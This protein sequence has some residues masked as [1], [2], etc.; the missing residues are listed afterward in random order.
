MLAP[1]E[2][3]LQECKNVRD[4]LRDTLRFAYSSKSSK[5][6]YA[7]CFQRLQLIE[8]AFKTLD[9]DNE[10]ILEELSNQLSDLSELIGRVERSRIEEFS[11]PFALALQSLALK[12]CTA[13][14]REGD[15][16]PCFF[17]SADDELN[18]YQ[19]ITEQSVPGFI[20][21]PLFNIIFP[22][23]L[24]N[25]VLLHPILGHELG[26]AAISAPQHSQMLLE[27]VLNPLTAK[28]PLQDL[29]KFQKWLVKIKADLDLDEQ[30]RAVD[31]WQEELYC[32][33]FGL[34]LMGPSYVG[35]T[36]SLLRP[37]KTRTASDSHPPSLTRFWVIEQAV[38]FLGWRA[39]LLKR[40]PLNKAIKRYFSSL[41]EL[42]SGVP[43]KY[44]LLSARQIQESLERLD[45]FLDTIP[46]VKCPT[47]D[48]NQIARMRA[49]MLKGCPPVA[50]DI[51][52]NLKIGNPSVDFRSVL[53]AGWLTWMSEEH[54]KSALDFYQLNMLCQR[55]ILQQSAVDVWN[56]YQ[57]KDTS[58][59]P[60][61]TGSTKTNS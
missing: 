29:T 22:R 6:V 10:D 47:Q 56:S 16:A 32:D 23:S 27:D 44:R 38:S 17:I 30:T 61:L 15:S 21:T 39:S 26:H 1:S 36:T 59:R 55:G 50:T 35:A 25:F 4:L 60:K 54:S 46:G 12:I 49:L 9:E 43:A 7:E 18:S 57:R 13:R 5:D 45:K 24:K 33:L 58:D 51:T 48:L 20:V 19:I 42:A 53:F 31:A 14:K 40:G 11:W 3:R 28:S 52:A 41:T 8:D 34:L 37:F 2:Y